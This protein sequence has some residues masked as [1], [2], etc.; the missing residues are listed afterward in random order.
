VCRSKNKGG[1][2]VKDLRKQNISIITKWWWKL[3][4]QEGL[5]QQIVRARYLGNKSVASVSSRFSD[6]PCWRSLLLVK[7]TYLAGRKTKMN[8][9]N[10]VRFWHDSWDIGPPLISLYPKL[11]NICQIQECSVK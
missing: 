7:E 3:D 9:D 1:L 8:I 6:S 2:G 10:L 4:T 11:F 5:W